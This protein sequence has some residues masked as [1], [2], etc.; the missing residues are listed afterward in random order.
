[1]IHPFD[2]LADGTDAHGFTPLIIAANRDH[3]E[4]ARMLLRHKANPNLLAN[5]GCDALICAVQSGHVDSIKQLIKYKANVDAG[6]D[7][8]RILAPVYSAAQEGHARVIKILAKAK[9]DL[10]RRTDGVAPIFISAQEGHTRC[11][12]AL[13]KAGADCNPKNPYNATPLFIAAQKGH[14][15][16]CKQLLKCKQVEIDE[17]TD[18]G[19]TPLHIAIQIGNFEVAKMLI[20]AGA[21]IESID[22]DGKTPL[23]TAADFGDMDITEILIKAGADLNKKDKRGRTAEIILKEEYG[24]DLN[25]IVIRHQHHIIH[26]HKTEEKAVA[27]T[28][29]DIF[30]TQAKNIFNHFDA[31]DDNILKEAELRNCLV[32]LGMD[33]KLGAE[34]F[35]VFVSRKCKIGMDFPAFLQLYRQGMGYVTQAKREDAKSKIKKYESDL[36]VIEVHS[37]S[38]PKRR[39]HHASSL[40]D[41]SH[42][43][44]VLPGV[45]EKIAVGPQLKPMRVAR[46]HDEST[47]DMLNDS[48]HDLSTPAS[49]KIHAKHNTSLK[50]VLSTHKMKLK[51]LPSFSGVAFNPRLK[52][53]PLGSGSRPLKSL[54]TDIKVRW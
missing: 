17:P 54:P 5:D 3:I 48:V 41:V 51:R 25:K 42:E 23:I 32:A 9:A 36:A 15:S 43:S 12:H 38:S 45:A 18:T 8:K 29:S 22:G 19:T 46:Q 34:K 40:N 35:E 14:V 2:A 7:D 16:V 49:S 26:H 6:S 39:N 13:I 50:R 52:L 24:E 21:K 47:P 44:V 30:Y 1:M 4:I 28:F 10:N 53:P 31:N 37:Q 27:S 11:V 33:K 20:K